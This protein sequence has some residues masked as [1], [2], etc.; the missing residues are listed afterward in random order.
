MASDLAP[1]SCV[2]GSPMY[3]VSSSNV[4]EAKSLRLQFL[5]GYSSKSGEAATPGTVCRV[6][7]S[8]LE[9]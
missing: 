5:A 1:A 9:S 8:S 6:G 2:L 7:I 3:W 4:L